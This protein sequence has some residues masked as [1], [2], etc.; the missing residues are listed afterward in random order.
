MLLD[1][2]DGTEIA[3]LTADD[4]AK[5]SEAMWG[6][7]V[8]QPFVVLHSVDGVSWSRESLDDLS[9]VDGSVPSQAFSIDGRVILTV[10]DGVTR[11][12]D[13]SAQTVVVVGT[14]TG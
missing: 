6:G 4:Q 14:P 5:L 7:G 9:G 3:R 11:N 1:V 13:G 8:T 2:A 10:L 12:D